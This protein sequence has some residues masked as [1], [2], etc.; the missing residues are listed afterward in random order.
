MAVG[1]PLSTPLL[2]AKGAPAL[3]SRARAGAA[4]MAMMAAA[5]FICRNISSSP[6]CFSRRAVWPQL[7]LRIG[8]SAQSGSLGG[9]RSRN[10]SRASSCR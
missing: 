6:N 8:L 1:D 3:F 2:N 10:S 4:G 7:V 5:L 9:R